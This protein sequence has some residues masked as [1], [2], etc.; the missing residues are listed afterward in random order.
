MFRSRR[1]FYSISTSLLFLFSQIKAR[2]VGAVDGVRD[3]IYIYM[4]LNIYT[5]N[6]QKSINY[7]IR[8]P[9][10]HDQSIIEAPQNHGTS[11]FFNQPTRTPETSWFETIFWDPNPSIWQVILRVF[12]P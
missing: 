3:D 9:K 7:Y 4:Y 5:Q 2:D 10:L 12:G 11:W 6:H 1:V 8:I